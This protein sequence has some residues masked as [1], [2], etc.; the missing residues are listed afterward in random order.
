MSAGHSYKA[1]V[2]RVPLKDRLV[3]PVVAFAENEATG[4]LLLMATSVVAL[5]WA[6]LGPAHSY[7]DFW[8]T[9]LQLGAGNAV[10]KMS[11]HHFINDGFMALFFLLVGLEIKREFLIGE[12]RDL[13]KASLSVFA[14]LGGMLV[15][16]GIYLLINAQGGD[17]RGAGVPMATDIAFSLG[18]LALLGPRCPVALKV[19]L[20][21]VAIV[22]DLGAV[23]VIAIFYS[24][25]IL[26]PMLAGMA[27]C[28]A[29]LIGLNRL[30]VRLLLPYLALGVV[31]WWFTLLSGIHATVA[32]VLLAMTIPV[33][34]HLF[35]EEFALTAR[36]AVE[37]FESWNAA[38]DEG[39]ITEGHQTAVSEL[40]AACERV[41]MPLQRLENLLA[42]WI[43]YLVLPVFALANAGIELAGGG[44]AFRD[45]VGIGIIAGL[46]IGKPIGV[47]GGTI[48]AM[49]LLKATLPEGVT[50]SMLIGV[51]LL[52][53][54]GFTMSLFI[55]EL[56]FIDP[57]RHEAAKLAILTV[58]VLMGVLGFLWLRRVTPS[59]NSA[60]PMPAPSA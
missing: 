50:R 51:G 22:D 35:P 16:A 15:P 47:I 48:L 21:A 39:C 12:L 60:K 37:S 57:A 9:K 7:H 14:A 17:P 18:V 27:V 19:F 2:A 3:K 41:Q 56:A 11:L 46:A 45:P 13:R 4:G 28:V 34:T 59:P 26:M 44:A 42:P 38:T 58:S 33:R 54:I 6:N 30:G 20:A 49:T 43:T 5:L 24:S 32:G 10:G 23:I 8:N 40:E 52:T 55:S 53:G 25:G 1:R 29:A 36:E 31:L